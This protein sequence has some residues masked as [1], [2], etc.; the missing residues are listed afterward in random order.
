MSVISTICCKTRKRPG[1]YI[2]IF[3]ITGTAETLDTSTALRAV[4]GSMFITRNNEVVHN[5]T[6][7]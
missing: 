6:F 3:A 5:Q 1:Q 7:I 2:Y 4:D